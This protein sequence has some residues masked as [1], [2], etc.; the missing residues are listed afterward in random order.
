MKKLL[1]K[2]VF[3]LLGWK[4]IGHVPKEIK[5]AVMVCA[6]HTSNW[7]FPLALSIFHYKGIKL[8]YFIK[9]S[10][11]FF[12]LNIF[13][14]AT[15][16]IGIDRSKSH[17]LVDS[18]ISELKK[19]EE[20]IVAVPAEGTRSWVEKWKTG[21]YHIAKGADVPLLLGFID[22]QKKELGFGPIFYLTGDFEK[23]MNQLQIFFREKKGK[24]PEKYN[25]KIF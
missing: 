5:K 22:Y 6:P 13:F 19:S 21:F 1:I 25:P 10:W 15:G 16:A 14:K 18:M 12:P 3:K 9:K 23:D 7:D 20:M 17:G 4:I 24:F 8:N 2:S 11:L